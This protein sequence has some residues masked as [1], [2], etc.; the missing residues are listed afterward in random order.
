MLVLVRC[1][2]VSTHMIAF[3]CRGPMV[4]MLLSSRCS[5]NDLLI[6]LSHYVCHSLLV[7]MRSI[8]TNKKQINSDQTLVDTVKQNVTRLG[9]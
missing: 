6:L 1:R 2:P 4:R 8:S 7:S 5:V 9:Y 3:L